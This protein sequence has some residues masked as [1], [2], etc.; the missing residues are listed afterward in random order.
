MNFQQHDQ[1]SLYEAYERFKLLKRKYPNHIIDDMEQMQIFTGGKKMQ[2]MML[3]DA[4]VGGSIKN[5]TDEE[6]KELIEQMCQNEYNTT[7]ERCTKMAGMVDIDNETAYKVEIE[8]LRRKLAEKFLPQANVSKVQE[9]CDFCHENH[10]SGQKMDSLGLLL[11][12][13]L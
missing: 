8:L 7:N 1:E 3:L 13:L 2:H 5:K 10:P 4:S 11:L 9:V 6:V 12:E